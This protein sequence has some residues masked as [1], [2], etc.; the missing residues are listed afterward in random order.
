MS[1]ITAELHSLL[2]FSGM[3]R[4]FNVPDTLCL[5]MGVISNLVQVLIKRKR[6]TIHFQMLFFKGSI[7]FLFLEFLR[8]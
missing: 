3:Y 5:T 8:L 1:V 7:P 4:F 6:E 2:F